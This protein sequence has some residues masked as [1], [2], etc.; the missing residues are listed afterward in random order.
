MNGNFYPLILSIKAYSLQEVEIEYPYKT[1]FIE[2]LDKMTFNNKN[3]REF[4]KEKKQELIESL[5]KRREVYGI[6][7][8]IIDIEL[9]G[10]YIKK[11]KRE[12]VPLFQNT[13]YK[14]IY[15]KTEDLLLKRMATGNLVRLYKL[16]KECIQEESYESLFL[17]CAPYI[18]EQL[19]ISAFITIKPSILISMLENFKQKRR[20]FQIARYLLQ[21]EEEMTLESFKRAIPAQEKKKKEIEQNALIRKE[22]LPY[23]DN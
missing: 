22:R 10:I 21:N 9:L 20:F 4:F 3:E 1:D 11:G 17:D 12:I 6:V 19:E 14:N 2:E 18:L 13:T 5:N 8:E 15:I 23:V 7:L 16:D